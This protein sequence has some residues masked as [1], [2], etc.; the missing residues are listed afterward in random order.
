MFALPAEFHFVKNWKITS[1]ET[2]LFLTFK[3]S[4]ASTNTSSRQLIIARQIKPFCVF[5]LR[6]LLRFY[7][8]TS[9]L[10]DSFKSVT[11]QKLS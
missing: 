6:D 4:V 2:N 8:G 11:L 3:I 5:C 9:M 7:Y 10:K 1:T